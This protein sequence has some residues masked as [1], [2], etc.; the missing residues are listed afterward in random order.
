MQVHGV[1]EIHQSLSAYDTRKRTTVWP[2]SHL[3]QHCLSDGSHVLNPELHFGWTI[4]RLH[5]GIHQSAVSR[6]NLSPMGQRCIT[7][8]RYAA[9]V[10]KL[11]VVCVL[12]DVVCRNRNMNLTNC[13]FL[14]CT[15]HTTKGDIIHTL[16]LSFLSLLL[17]I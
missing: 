10:R 5:Q 9:S 14:Y 3:P 16:H 6:E 15:I 11:S 17:E 7:R 4:S 2:A 8:C 12:N 1:S 13:L